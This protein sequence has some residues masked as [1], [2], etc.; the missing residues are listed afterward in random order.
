MMEARP[1]ID[2]HTRDGRLRPIPVV[3]YRQCKIRVA[4]VFYT[5]G[6]LDGFAVVVYSGTV[7]QA[8]VFF[9]TLRAFRSSYQHNW[10]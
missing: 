1:E 4:Y 8:H 7:C 6:T 10:T 5:A 2:R 9:F 3:V